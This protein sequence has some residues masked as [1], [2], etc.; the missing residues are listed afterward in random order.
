NIL[1]LLE[2]SPIDRRIAPISHHFFAI[3]TLLIGYPYVQLDNIYEE[4]FTLLNRVYNIS[5]NNES[6]LS[7]LQKGPNIRY[8]AKDIGLIIRGLDAIC[9]WIDGENE[10]AKLQS[11]Q[12][13]SYL[14]II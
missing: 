13:N 9:Q 7:S 8:T 11:I 1:G 10:Q 14:N 5:Y 2:S 4:A 6:Q 12:K 3:E